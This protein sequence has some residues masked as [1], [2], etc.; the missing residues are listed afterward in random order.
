VDVEHCQERM[1]VRIKSHPGGCACVSPVQFRAPPGPEA[2]AHGAAARAHAGG[3]AGPPGS[4]VGNQ[5]N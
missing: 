5:A 2:R 1:C 3:G 4:A